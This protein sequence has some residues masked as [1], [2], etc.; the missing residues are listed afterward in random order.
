[1]KAL[2]HVNDMKGCLILCCL[3]FVAICVQAGNKE[4]K[5]K[6]VDIYYC[7]EGGY[8]IY[9]SH[10]IYKRHKNIFE[11]HLE[12]WR[13]TN[14]VKSLPIAIDGF[15]V[16]TF[17]SEM[18]KMRKDTCGT[19]RITKKDIE[20][21]REYLIEDS[22]YLSMMNIDIKKHQSVS[23]QTLL[24]LT[25]SEIS[26]ALHYPSN[27]RSLKEYVVLTFSD[28]NTIELRPY[29]FYSGIPWIVKKKDE[30][31]FLDYDFFYKFIKQIGWEGHFPWQYDRNEMVFNVVSYLLRKQEN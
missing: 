27:M 1:M 20:N 9:N 12:D 2:W 10:A 28:G 11:F 13:K 6:R 4:N 18:D 30:S 14:N 8:G 21:Y 15:F 25:C 26:E 29:L 23:D 31:Y 19:Y 16:D 3:L 17:V 24:G 5:V 7:H 22:A